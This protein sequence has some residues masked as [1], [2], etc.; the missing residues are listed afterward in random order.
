MVEVEQV[1]NDLGG[2]L[3]RTRKRSQQ[4]TY[5]LAEIRDGLY[6]SP[7]MSE[8]RLLDVFSAMQDDLHD[9][10]GEVRSMLYIAED[11]KYVPPD[12]ADERRNRCR[13]ISAGIASLSHHLRPNPV[14]PRRSR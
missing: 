1:T 3:G 7:A 2:V 5:P 9:L 10:A 6:G 12:L 11:R 14:P 13:Q 4:V 8:E